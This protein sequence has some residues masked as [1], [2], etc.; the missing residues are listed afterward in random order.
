MSQKGGENRGRNTL[1]DG[2]KNVTK[3]KDEGRLVA[4]CKFLKKGICKNSPNKGVDSLEKLG[5]GRKR[6][7]HIIR[8]VSPGAGEGT[9]GGRREGFSGGLSTKDQEK[10]KN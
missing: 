9:L 1:G 10:T 6:R 4:A 3:S 5:K 8:W 7:V 2:K